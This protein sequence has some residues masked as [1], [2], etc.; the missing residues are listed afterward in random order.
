M[1][2]SLE[3]QELVILG[4][5]Q[6]FPEV[7]QACTALGPIFHDCEEANIQELLETAKQLMAANVLLQDR[8]KEMA[9]QYIEVP[10]G[11]A[12]VKATGEVPRLVLEKRKTAYPIA[13]TAWA[14]PNARRH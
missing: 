7:V 13:W 4:E 12:T 3:E 8:Y 11:L 10:V 6:P 1:N 2:T 5:Q 14:R 9:G